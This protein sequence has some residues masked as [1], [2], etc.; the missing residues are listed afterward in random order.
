MT[1]RPQWT[2]ETEDRVVE[3]VLRDQAR[4]WGYIKKLSPE[5]LEQ[6]VRRQEH[7][8]SV[9]ADVRAVLQA[10]ADT[11]LLLP[12]GPAEHQLL[13]METKL[14]ATT[15]TI[16]ASRDWMLGVAEHLISLLEADAGLNYV[17]WDIKPAGQ[18]DP[19]RM[20]LVRPGGKSPHELRLEAE[21]EL[22]RLRVERLVEADQDWPEG[23]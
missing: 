22:L 14:G 19:Y 5:V 7:G 20:I 18:A 8:P 23:Y 16:E 1:D 11:G 6:W 4:R 2:H 13:S 10:L 21:Q 3:A 17:Q 12:P 15:V 9:K